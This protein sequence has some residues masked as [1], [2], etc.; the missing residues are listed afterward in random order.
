MYTGEG[1]ACSMNNTLTNL[2]G[3]ALFT[4]RPFLPTLRPQEAG[5][6]PLGTRRGSE[7]RTGEHTSSGLLPS[8][9]L[10]LLCLFSTQS[11]MSIQTVGICFIL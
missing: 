9:R 6:G 8:G 4:P 3:T 10:S 2:E 7:A 11:F 1:K 5:C